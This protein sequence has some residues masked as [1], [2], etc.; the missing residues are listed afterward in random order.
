MPQ[1]RDLIIFDSLPGNQRFIS[2]YFPGRRHI[3][4]R[5]RPYFA[6]LESGANARPIGPHR[7]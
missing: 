3:N 4:V 7:A 6:A 2:T 1:L 5:D